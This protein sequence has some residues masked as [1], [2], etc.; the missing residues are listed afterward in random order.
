MNNLKALSSVFL[1]LSLAMLLPNGKVLVAGGNKSNGDS[2]GA[3]EIY[4]VFK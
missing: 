4:E 2:H 1:T 3:D